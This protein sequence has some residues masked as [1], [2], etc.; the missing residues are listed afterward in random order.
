ML[1][2]AAA[3]RLERRERRAALVGMT[4]AAAGG[5]AATELFESLR[6]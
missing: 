6:D 5:K 2:H 3:K 4:H 1:H